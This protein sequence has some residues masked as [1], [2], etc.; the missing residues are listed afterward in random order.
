M[1]GR[2]VRV[3]CI[4]VEH[5]R[6]GFQR[7]FEFFLAECNC[8]VVVVRT[9][10]FEIN[11]VAHEPPANRAIRCRACSNKFCQSLIVARA[12]FL[13]LRKL[14]PAGTLPKALAGGTSPGLIGGQRIPASPA[15]AASPTAGR[16]VVAAGNI[17]GAF[18]FLQR[19]DGIE[20]LGA[21]FI[22]EDDFQ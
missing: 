17:A 7:F 12:R 11:A 8:L 18:G 3:A 21:E 15:K 6:A 13:H 19:A 10:D 16:A 20:K 4:T 14:L 5:Q 22:I 2:P 9:N 1:G